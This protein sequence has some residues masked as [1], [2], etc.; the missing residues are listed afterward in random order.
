MASQQDLDQGGTV[1]QTQKIYLGPSV[2]WVSA[3][4]NNI[5]P[6]T[7]AGTTNVLLGATLVTLNVAGLVTVQLFSAKGN[8]AG[9]Q[10]V[11]GSFLYRPVT[12]VDIGGNCL[13]YPATILPYGA[14]TID[15]LPS[16]PISVNYGAFTLSPNIPAGGWTL[17]QQ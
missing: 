1:R 12:I 5:L 13:T 2:G 7:A 16:I 10:A 8:H 9:A 6:I 14:E 15:G 3:G 17:T 11:P 4:A